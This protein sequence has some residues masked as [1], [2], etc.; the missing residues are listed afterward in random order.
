MPNLSVSEAKQ[1]K[2][3]HITVSSTAHALAG[4]VDLKDF[5]NIEDI[6]FNNQRI[7]SLSNYY[8]EQIVK[9]KLTNCEVK[10]PL[11]VFSSALTDLDVSNMVGTFGNSFEGDLR[12]AISKSTSLSVVDFGSPKNATVKHAISGRLPI[13][14]DYT[15]LTRFDVNYC[16]FIDGEL[17]TLKN[18]TSLVTFNISG[19]GIESIDDDFEFPNNTT[20]LAEF[21]IQD[22][23]N[24]SSDDIN[25]VVDAST[26]VNC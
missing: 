7:Q 25:R 24:L 11:P 26:V 13:F 15:S 3:L 5:T 22:C 12:V 14:A 2:K 19:T 16:E 4:D 21:S 17:S 10:Q 1:I 9:L 23:P 8:P 6:D 20:T 18:N